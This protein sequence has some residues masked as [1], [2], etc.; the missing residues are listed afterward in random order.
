[1]YG[2]MNV[3]KMR[4]YFELDC[5]K[6]GE[7]NGELCS[8]IRSAEGQVAVFYLKIFRNTVVFCLCRA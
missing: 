6:L 8:A 5:R 7:D 3:K 1:M 4:S 2:T